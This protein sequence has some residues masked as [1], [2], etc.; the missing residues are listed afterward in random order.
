MSRAPG[1][2]LLLAVAASAAV[3]A[4]PTDAATFGER[5]WVYVSLAAGP[6][7]TEELA[8]ILAGLAASQ[9]KLALGPAITLMSV[10]GWVATTLLYILG[11]WRGRWVRRRFPKVGVTVKR[12]LRAVRRRPWRSA[13]A[14]RFVFGLRLLLPLACGAA[15][16]RLDI[17]LLG[18]LVSSV[19]WSALFAYLGFWFGE[20]AMQGLRQVRAYDQYVGVVA[21]LVVLAW[22]IIRRR[23]RARLAAA[24]RA[25]EG[26]AGDGRATS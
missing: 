10:G 5:L 17:Y 24:E 14:V 16:L 18:S 13:L 2:L 20:A 21:G 22:L 4:A 26:A 23:T 6:I 12:L 9:G 19:L 3:A 8:P 25:R 7:L 11:R 15:H 1:H